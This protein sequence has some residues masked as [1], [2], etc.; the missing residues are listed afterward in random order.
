MELLK[1]YDSSSSFSDEEL[2]SLGSREVR[3]VYLVTYSQVDTQKF[4]SRRSFAEAVARSVLQHGP[5]LFYNVCK[6][7]IKR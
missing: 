1:E 4:P 5:L 2:S 7:L 6:R 3:Q